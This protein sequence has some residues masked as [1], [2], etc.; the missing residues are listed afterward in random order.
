MQR[1]PLLSS[2]KWYENTFPFCSVVQMNQHL[3][4]P[5]PLPL[6]MIP[7]HLCPPILPPSPHCRRGPAHHRSIEKQH[8]DKGAARGSRLWALHPDPGRRRPGCSPSHLLQ[9]VIH[10]HISTWPASRL[11]IVLLAEFV[12][13]TST[14]GAVFAFGI[15]TTTEDF[16]FFFP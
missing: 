16:F 11:D 14:K 1:V 6:I 13:P 9:P 12:Q 15:N 4:L 2:F 5:L 7:L 8:S 3:P 10:E